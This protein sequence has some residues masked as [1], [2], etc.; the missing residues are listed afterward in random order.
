M[1]ND[2]Q[3]SPG[4]GRPALRGNIMDAIKKGSVQMRPRWHFVL[5]SA[6]VAVGA[7]I[8]LLGLMYMASLS[9]FFLHDTGAWFVPSFGGRGW[10]SFLQSIPWLLIILIVVLAALLEVIVRRYAFVYRKPLLLSAVCILLVVIMGGFLI[11]ATPFHRQMKF[12]L[13]HN[14]L[15]PPLA[16]VYGAPFRAPPPPDVYNGTILATTTNGFIIDDQNGAGTTTVVITNQT[17]LPDGIDF[18]VGTD[19]VVVGDR[20]GSSTVRAFGV[21]ESDE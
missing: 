16:F 5:L 15:P 9:V 21:R 3:N 18:A 8:V 19:V 14:Q 12:Y 2:Q 7:L 1:N 4:D 11:A 20:L 17:R 10:F 13:V 6:V